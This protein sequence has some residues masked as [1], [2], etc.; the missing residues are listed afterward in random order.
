MFSD[1]YMFGIILL[2]KEKYDE[3]NFEGLQG[4]V[5]SAQSHLS[6]WVKC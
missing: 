2:E 3:T 1:N 4:P 6:Q 5:R